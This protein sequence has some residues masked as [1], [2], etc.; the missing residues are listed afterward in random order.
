MKRVVHHNVNPCRLWV[1]RE[2]IHRPQ[3][4]AALH[5]RKM[6]IWNMN[7]IIHFELLDYN[8]TFAKEVNV[9]L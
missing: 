6:N 8:K 7:E 1:S 5:L 9:I 2:E 3:A 4:K